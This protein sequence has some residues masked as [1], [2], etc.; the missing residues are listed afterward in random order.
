MTLLEIFLSYMVRF[1]II[2]SVFLII[3]YYA[4]TGIRTYFASFQNFQFIR[5]AYIVST[6]ITL[7]GFLLTIS[8]YMNGRAIQSAS[9]NLLI[10]IVFIIMLPKILL[11]CALLVEDVFRI[12]WSICLWIK[13]GGAVWQF[14]PRYKLFTLIG[15]LIA[16]VMM[17]IMIKGVFFNKYRYKV[18]RLTLY[19]ENLPISFENYT[20]VQISDVHSGSF[21]NKDKVEKGID[22]IN[23]QNPDLVLFTGDI[24]N[25]RSEEFFPYIPIF[26]KIKARDGKFSIL[27][28]HDYGDYVRFGSPVEKWRNH[29]LLEVY[30]HRAGFNL[31]LN[32][33]ETIKK[34]NDS[35]FIVGV[36]N[37]GHAPFPKRGKLDVA[38]EGV[39]NGAFVVLLSHDPSHW[40]S[41][42]THQKQNIAL[43]LSGH[44]HGMQFGID[45]WG[46]KWSPVQWKYP[47]W[48][49]L[50]RRNGMKLYVNVGFGFIGLPGRVGILPEITVFTLKKK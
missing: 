10:G 16:S 34:G 31:L 41:V 18:K 36:E 6:V 19:F 21:D 29:H 49:G 2:I 1:I 37:W 35:I 22:L 23:A 30:E 24:V 38:M 32:R 20:I 26:T 5:I 40:D 14:I 47:L 50:Y 8:M 4:W 39:P 9:S 12:F 42:V 48:S 25:M 45:F 17:V 44:T 11:G 43:T 7:I 13:H 15:L 28:N 3:D 46:M 27:G 33:H